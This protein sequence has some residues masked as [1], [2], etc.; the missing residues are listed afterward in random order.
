[1]Q[2]APTKLL[3]SHQPLSRSMNPRS[4]LPLSLSVL[5]L[6]SSLTAQNTLQVGPGGFVD[7]QAAIDAAQAG[8]EIVVAPGAYPAFT[9]LI[10][11][12]IRAEQPG[13]VS[14]GGP[15]FA[16]VSLPVGQRARL[17]A[18]DFVELVV[19]NATVA[20]EDCSFSDA[21]VNLSLLNSTVHLERCTL[22]GQP[23][24]F[25]VEANMSVDNSTVSMVD[26]NFT[27]AP[28]SATGTTSSAISL[29]NNSYLVGS[30]LSL[31]GGLGALPTPAVRADLTSSVRISDSDFVVDGT[32]CAIEASDAVCDRCTLPTACPSLGQ[33]A[34]LGIESSGPLQA[35]Q[36][37]TASFRGAPNEFVLVF[38]SG[39][40]DAATNPLLLG[41]F[42][43]DPAGCF[44]AAL[45]TTDASGAASATWQIP[46][47]PLPAGVGLWFQGVMGPTFPLATSAAIG[48][49]AR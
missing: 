22:T 24:F 15:L 33:A 13:T 6:G 49:V 31:T 40:I 29:R 39:E 37:L 45:L 14:I 34:L 32:L 48:G 1:M 38:G 10:G 18:L 19:F 28:S 3:R 17:V 36:P 23:F 44:V 9:C 12:T 41:P 5:S 42:L 7:V 8:D 20:I 26:C 2:S 47:A 4:L 43:L 30:R 35:G 16:R 27:G 11:V 46:A 25:A 21:G